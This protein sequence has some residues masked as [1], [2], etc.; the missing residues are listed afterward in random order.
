MNCDGIKGIF[1]GDL[2]IKTAIELSLKDM[3]E[4]PWLIE[5]AFGSLVANPLLNRIYGIKEINKA[6]E[7]ILNN[8]IPVY[9]H[10]RIDKMEF[11]CITISMGASTEDR[12]LATLGDA[13]PFFEE[14]APSE[15]GKPIPYL[16]PPFD[17][18]SYDPDTGLLTVSDSE[19][20]PNII[21]IHKGMILVEPKSGKG[22]IIEGI[23][24]S[25]QIQLA[26]NL[27]LPKGPLA[28][29]P[30]KPLWKARREMAR[31]QE[32][33][34]IG[35][36]VDGD[37][38]YLIFL[39]G[40]VK[41]ALFRYREALLEANNFQLSRLSSSDMLKNQYL[42]IENGYSRWITLSGQIEETWVK[43][44][45]RYIEAIAFQDSSNSIN[46]TG[47]KIISKKAVT[48]EELQNDLWTT[49]DSEVDE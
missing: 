48:S 40:V 9:M 41:Y 47:I 8:E 28:V 4:N 49:I 2:I 38:S 42:H 5:D 3:R 39:Y 45:K 33:Y 15:I 13:S 29:I 16:I 14:Y 23:N 21:Y 31:S 18:E 30:S 10:H 11:P 26:T 25:C 17:Y 22:Y 24:G 32:Q 1:Q 27:S 44:P 20:L 12:D 19:A 37:P 7:F 43:A 35:C 34:N 46:D 36:H 6:K